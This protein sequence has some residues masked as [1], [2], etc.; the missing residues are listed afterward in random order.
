MVRYLNIVHARNLEFFRDKTALG[1][2]ILLPVMLVFGFTYM[3]SG[4]GKSEYKIGIIG[5]ID[6]LQKI[7]PDF[8]QLKYTKFVSLASEADALNKLKH[9]H[10]DMIINPA[11]KKYWVNSSSKKGYFL[12][13]IL[14]GHATNSETILVKSIIS[15][16]EVRYI[17]WVTPGILA[18]NMMFNC[19]FGIGYTVVHYRKN[20]VLK[21]LKATPVKPIEFL[22]AQ[23]T[24]RL[25]IITSIT[26]TVYIGCD[27]F[28][29]FL[30]LGSYFSLFFVFVLGAICLISLGLIMAA[31]TKSEEFASGALN[32]LIWPMML[33]SG[34]WFSLEGSPIYIQQFS[35]ILPLTHLVEASRAIMNDG[36]SLMEVKFNLICLTIMSTI[37]LLIGAK[38]FRWD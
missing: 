23:V 2:S 7:S 21:R 29:G 33:L 36:A 18:T 25:F 14:K 5:A 9:H 6:D 4:S 8:T 24:S 11:S 3:F 31:R 26:L 15:G 20:G 37:F 38:L 1:W 35:Q 13:N 12:E 10:Y 28:I 19:L 30:M 22:T 17:D 32:I 16:K 34:V 27:F